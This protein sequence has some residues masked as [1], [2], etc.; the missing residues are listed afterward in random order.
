MKK[1]LFVGGTGT[2]SSAAAHR[3][4]QEGWELTLLHRSASPVPEGAETLQADINDIDTVKQLLQG[5]RFDAVADFVAFQPQ[6]ILRDFSLFS[7]CTDQYLFISSASAYQKPM[8]CFRIT[9]S[10]PL[11]NPYWKYARDK[12]ACEALLME[13]YRKNDFPVTIVRPSH[14]YGP[15]KV[16]VAIHGEKGCWQVLSRML[17]GRPVLVHGDGLS[18]W[19]V[20]WNED[21]A[22]GFSGLMGNPLAVGEA[23]H[24]TADESVTW[25]QIYSF[26]GKVLG[27]EPH[28]V[29]ISSEMLC[30][31]RPSLTGTLL[32]DKAYSVSFDNHK[33]KRLVPGFS[34]KVPAWQG[35]ARAVQSLLENPRLQVPDEA[36]DSW[37]DRTIQRYFSILTA[38]P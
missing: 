2:I 18:L 20:T 11:V 7:G 36:F 3:A 34:A 9:E 33:I 4:L 1:A 14:T 37:C 6:D 30:A 29:H 32:G 35:I 26:I 28:L 23:V 19:T 5:R 17:A 22:R 16:P 24:I 10:T 21:F 38:S 12:A 31:L 27:K 13:L 8:N 25:N 15:G